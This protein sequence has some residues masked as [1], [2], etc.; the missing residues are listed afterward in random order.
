M[1]TFSGYRLSSL[2]QSMLCAA[3]EFTLSSF[4]TKRLKESL[5][6]NIHVVKDLYL[7]EYTWGDV[8]AEE[9]GERFPKYFN[10]R[11]NYS[12]IE[13][14]YKMLV[15]LVHEIIHVKQYAKK[16]LKHLRQP[17]VVSYKDV[18]YNT[19]VVNY[20]DRPWE[21]EANALEEVLTM[22]FLE[23]HKRVNKYV[24]EKSDI[25]YMKEY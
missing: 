14:F 12:G 21:Q 8:E 6:I 5:N 19:L 20:Y 23:K 10:V 9:D 2:Q 24:V 25:N 16:E 3:T 11:I 22:K 7:K 1:I 15:V 13:S 18:K 17:F 4:M